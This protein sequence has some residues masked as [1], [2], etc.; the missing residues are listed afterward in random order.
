MVKASLLKRILAF[1]I[2]YVVVVACIM[3]GMLIAFGG[4]M[5]I[6]VLAAA[7][8]MGFLA[9]LALPIMILGWAVAVICSVGYMLIKDGLFGGRSLGK[10]L[11]GMKVVTKE[12]KAC[13]YK[14]SLFRNIVYVIPLMMFVELIMLFVDKDGERFGDKIAGTQ[15]VE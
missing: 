3:V 8:K 5:V 9:V 7:I 11:L 4:S 14:K 6:T 10:K 12:G 1:L 2:D 15:V 13:D